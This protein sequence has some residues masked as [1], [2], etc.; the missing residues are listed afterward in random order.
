MKFKMLLLLVFTMNFIWSAHAD[1]KIEKM[2]AAHE[3]AAKC[4]RGGT[5]P[6]VCHEAIHKTCKEN[7]ESGKCPMH[8]KKGRH[9]GK[10]PMHSEGGSCSKSESDETKDKVVKPGQS[11]KSSKAESSTEKTEK[12]DKK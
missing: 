7:M 5:D 10:C 11:D 9:H 6:K 8:D 12:S 4:L 3:E 2:A 1:E